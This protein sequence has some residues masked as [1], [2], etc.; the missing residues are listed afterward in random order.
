VLLG[1]DHEL[2]LYRVAQEALTN[3]RK[4][5]QAAHVVVD[6]AFAPDVVRLDIRDD[7]RG[8]TVP[9]SVT[10]LGQRGRFGLMGIHERVW[11]VG[12]EL[13]I[14]SSAGAG[15]WLRV[16]IPMNHRAA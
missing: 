16:T 12:G 5:A 15:T 8:F 11:S 13:S 14:H 10:E 4:H 2:V 6:L 7:G 3:I 9:G 1:T